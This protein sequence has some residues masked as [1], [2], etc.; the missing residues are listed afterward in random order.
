MSVFARVDVQFIS[1]VAGCDQSHSR[2][3]DPRTGLPVHIW[4]LTC[5]A[6]EAWICGAG[7]PKVM[8][9]EPDGQGGFRQRWVSQMQPTWARSVDEIPMTPDAERAEARRNGLT[10]RAEQS[11]LA[12]GIQNTRLAL[13]Y[14]PAAKEILRARALAGRGAVKMATCHSC[15][16][17]YLV[18][19]QYCPQCAVRVGVP[20]AAGVSEFVVDLPQVPQ[21]A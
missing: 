4:E 6:H 21:E 16:S 11:A 5:P 8:Q 2:P 14:R 13:E 1:S 9:W 12:E 15:H 7:K 3:V 17:D 10:R 19:A 18:G 20:E